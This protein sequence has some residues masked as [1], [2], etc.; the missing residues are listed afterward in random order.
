VPQRILNNLV[1]DESD[2]DVFTDEERQVLLPER[3]RKRSSRDKMNLL[4][5]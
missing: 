5:Y 2:D 3:I 4:S 1:G